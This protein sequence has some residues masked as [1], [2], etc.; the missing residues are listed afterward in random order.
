MKRIAFLLCLCIFLSGCGQKP[1]EPAIRTV[2]GIQVEYT[3][4]NQVLQRNYTKSE[5]VQSV[6][7]YLRLLRPYGTVIP[8]TDAPT[9]CKIILQ[10]SHGPDSVYLQLGNSYLR[11]NDD[12]WESIDE[13]RAALL[14]P[15]LLL[16]PSDS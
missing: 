13:N 14:Y 4:G 5:N 10:F 9:S 3:Q 1:Q 15:M 6:L 16:L 12:D 2:V 11:R 7:K 8:E